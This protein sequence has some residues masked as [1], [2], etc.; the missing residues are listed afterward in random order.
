MKIT[1]KHVDAFVKKMK[2][3]MGIEMFTKKDLLNGM[4]VELEHGKR[5]KETNVTSD[6]VLMTGKIA[7]AHLREFPDYYERLDILESMAD[8]YWKDKPKKRSKKLSKK[9]SKKSK[10]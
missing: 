4:N 5:S 6:N 8:K 1:S 3:N 9:S 2:L 7:L 10:K